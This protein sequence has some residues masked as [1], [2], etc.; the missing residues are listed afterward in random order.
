M[1]I[2]RHDGDSLGMDSAKVCIFEQTDKVGLACLLE[3]HHSRTLETKI[4]FEILSDLPNQTLE[5]Q[6]ADQQLSRLLVAS[7]LPESYCSGPVTVRLLYA[8]GSRGALPGCLR[9]QLLPRSLS[10]G[11]FSGCLLGSSH[12]QSSTSVSRNVLEAQTAGL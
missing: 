2:F 1:D 6:L 9:G 8:A 11:G 4:G 7:N 10:S 12:R 5:R 3:S